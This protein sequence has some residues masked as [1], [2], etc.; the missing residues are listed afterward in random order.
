VTLFEDEKPAAALVEARNILTISCANS[1]LQQDIRQ[2]LK[3]PCPGLEPQAQRPFFFFI[4]DADSY[5]GANSE[6]AK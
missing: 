2:M 4:G 1:D 6:A 5:I 3:A